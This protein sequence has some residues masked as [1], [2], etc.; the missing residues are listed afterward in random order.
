MSDTVQDSFVTI[1][2]GKLAGQTADG[3]TAFLGIPYAAPPFGK[4]RMRPPRP[5]EPWHGTRDAT[6]YGPTVPKDEYPPVYQ[7]LFPEVVFDGEHCLNLNV[8]TPDP[9]ATG[10]PVFVW[11]HGGSFMNGSGSIGEYDG[12]AFARDRIV[13]VTINYRLSA[14]GFLYLGDG[15]SNLGLLDQIAALQWVRDNIVAFGGDP[16]Q[17]TVGG[18]SAGAMSVTT[19]MSMPLADGLFQRA[20]LQSGA[21]A[22]SLTPDQGRLVAGH[23]AEALGVPATREAIADVPIGQLAKTAADLVTKVQTNPDPGKW[24]SL[25]LTM[26]PF[27]PAIDGDVL[28]AAPLETFAKGH[29]RDIPV[30]V[31]STRD[32]ARLFLIAAGTIDLVDEATLTAGAGAY[33]LSP[34]A[35]AQ[36]RKNRPVASPGDI[37]AAVATDWHFRIPALR[38][39]EARGDGAPTWV[40]RFDYPE[41]AD[42]YGLGACHGAEIPYVFD[43][44]GLPEIRP[45][46]GES[47]SAAVVGATHGAWVAFIS[48]GDPGWSRYDL[49]RRVTGLITD[50]VTE[51]A[52]PDGD[53]RVL[54]DGI[55]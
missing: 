18:E 44:T 50:E 19:L 37:L 24:G 28:P 15:L 51:A 45:R 42:N 27:A 10:L 32:E 2:S 54:W 6:Q 35:V 5:V 49:T 26:L 38:V 53:E 16:A 48:G 21:G 9:N 11:I 14:D 55:R 39:A 29:N 36:Y 43:T 31:G 23:L 1:K 13:C 34:E 30:L 25:A 7:P 22:Y 12:S 46:I 52:D 33:G 40:Y 47:P 20:I 41:P 4:N 3:V 8:W 17:V